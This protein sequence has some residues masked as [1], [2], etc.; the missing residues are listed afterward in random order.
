MQTDIC[1]ERVASLLSSVTSKVTTFALEFGRKG[2]TWARHDVPSDNPLNRIKIL[3]QPLS[4]LGRRVYRETGKRMT[5]ILIASN[6]SGLVER[7]PEFLKVGNTWQGERVIGGRRNDHLWSFLAAAESERLE[8]D[9]S[10]LAC[11][12]I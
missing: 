4:K 8:V 1:G 7:L 10:V 5:L 12:R 11:M 9:D 3:D 6:P 2:E